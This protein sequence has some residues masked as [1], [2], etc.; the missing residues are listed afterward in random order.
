MEAVRR[1]D[2]L[3]QPLRNIF[4]PSADGGLISRD[5]RVSAFL[6]PSPMLQ[7]SA[8]V[9][10]ARR[11]LP[12]AQDTFGRAMLRGA[13]NIE[14]FTVVIVV[15][16]E[17]AVW[18]EE[19]AVVWKLR[20]V[21]L[22]VRRDGM[23]PGQRLQS[24]S[25]TGTVRSGFRRASREMTPWRASSARTTFDAPGHKVLAGVYRSEMIPRGFPP[26]DGWHV[27]GHYPD[28]GWFTSRFAGGA[29]ASPR[30][31]DET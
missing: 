15:A 23:R 27:P 30:S 31:A 13:D 22:G 25:V 28:R 20:R 4:I 26:G 7:A 3:L 9:I 18:R 19:Q 2:V 29:S 8:T 21:I 14:M 11:R 10:E 16:R 6:Y 5:H 24:A 1:D 17:R 12:V